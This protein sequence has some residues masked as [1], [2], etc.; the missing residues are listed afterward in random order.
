MLAEVA[1]MGRHRQA[2]R[3]TLATRATPV[4]KSRRHE[5]SF[6]SR[7]LAR[8]SFYLLHSLPQYFVIILYIK[9]VA[10]I[11]LKSSILYYVKANEPAFKRMNILIII[12]LHLFFLFFYHGKKK[13]IFLTFKIKKWVFL[14]SIKPWCIILCFHLQVFIVDWCMSYLNYE[15]AAASFKYDKNKQTDRVK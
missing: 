1:E 3:R 10:H 6:S 14:F 15:E 2:K 9:H 12:I 4:R 7:L 5:V 8:I 11:I 13:F